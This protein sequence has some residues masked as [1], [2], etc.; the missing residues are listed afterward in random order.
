MSKSMSTIYQLIS[1]LPLKFVKND[2]ESATVYEDG[3]LVTDEQ[4]DEVVSS[5]LSTVY[6]YTS[7][8]TLLKIAAGS[9]ANW[10]SLRATSAAYLNDP[11]EIEH[12]WHCIAS[13]YEVL[14]SDSVLR[15]NVIREPKNDV[16]QV[17]FT[18]VGEC[19]SEIQ[20]KD[21][22]GRFNKLLDEI[23]I[24]SFT[25]NGDDLNQWILYG[26]KGCGIAIGLDASKLSARD[27]YLSSFVVYSE[28]NKSLLA[29]HIIRILVQ[30]FIGIIL[31]EDCNKVLNDQQE[32]IKIVRIHALQLMACCSLFK[33]EGFTAEREFRIISSITSGLD[34]E[35]VEYSHRGNRIAPYVKIAYPDQLP[36]VKLITGPCLTEQDLWT[37]DRLVHYGKYAHSSD[38]K[39]IPSVRVYRG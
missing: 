12:G 20:N 36:I 14:K 16:S 22:K 29:E 33:D 27:D 26:E 25:L 6:H 8:N 17:A 11:T 21:D 10:D 31:K 15:W 2:L 24:S 5:K 28:K 32:H 19:L 30:A 34:N 18:M 38:V 3:R 1:E 37:I 4:L 39:V 9:T 13:K 7:L 23:F 35:Q